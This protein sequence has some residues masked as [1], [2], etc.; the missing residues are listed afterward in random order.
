MSL[1]LPVYHPH[2][3]ARK[4]NQTHGYHG[5]QPMSAHTTNTDEQTQPTP[6]NNDGPGLDDVH[7]SL[8]ERRRR[9]LL[10]ILVDHE[11]ISKSDLAEAVASTEYDK[12]RDELTDA[13][14]KRVYVSLHQ[15]HLPNLSKHGFI[16]W[17]TK[18][19]LITFGP[20]SDRILE[21]LDYDSGSSSFTDR[22]AGFF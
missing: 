13:E 5:L 16:S 6:N 7:N 15:M 20:Y 12:P 14:V 21:Y 4:P 22:F 9:I 8:S 1:L 17:D 3:L 18:N 11:P 10:R 2:S 19:N